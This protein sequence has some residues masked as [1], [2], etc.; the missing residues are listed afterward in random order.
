M[1]D[2]C[3]VCPGGNFMETHHLCKGKINIDITLISS[4][5]FKARSWTLDLI[6]NPAV[7]SGDM[8][9]KGNTDL[10]IRGE[11]NKRCYQIALWE[12]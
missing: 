8:E 4:G 7:Q 6:R 1:N 12:V 3:T 11:S 2:V 10:H 9:I 5:L